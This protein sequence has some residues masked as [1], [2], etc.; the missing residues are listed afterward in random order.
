MYVSRKNNSKNGL[1]NPIEETIHKMEIA[2]GVTTDIYDKN[3]KSKNVKIRHFG[4]VVKLER[5]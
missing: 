2:Y 3:S 1:K 5:I 4:T